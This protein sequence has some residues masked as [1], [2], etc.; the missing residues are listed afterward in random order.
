MKLTSTAL[1]L[2]ALSAAALVFADDMVAMSATETKP[3]KAGSMVPETKLVG[4]DGKDVALA[5]VLGGKPT[6]LIFYRGGWCPYCN[7]H[8]ADLMKV[9][10]DLVAKGY[11]LI[12]I[13]P[14][15]AEELNKSME[16]EKLAYKLYSDS[17]ADA[18]K[19]F[20]IAF[21][22]EDELVAKYKNDYKIDLEKASGQT[23]HILPVPS[24]FVV[25]PSGKIIYA[26][27][28]PDYRVRLKG[29]EV[30]EAVESAGWGRSAGR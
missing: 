25:D 20:G 17:S 2:T 26:Y 30:L 7:R 8:L 24:V 16:K 28:N 23:H 14:D 27:S 21:K 9:E 29:E 5:S 12:G 6:V 18:M 13:S 22:V 1:C 19:K 11:Q 4:M 3:M 10:K 15:T